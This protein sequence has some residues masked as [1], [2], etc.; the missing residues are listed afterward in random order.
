MPN[1]VRDLTN[2]IFNRLTA[3]E[4]VSHSKPG[5]YWRCLCTCG[6]EVTRRSSQ[7]L[8]NPSQIKS[9]GCVIVE[10]N[11]R[12]GALCYKGNP[13]RV[14]GTIEYFKSNTW[15][16]LQ[17]RTIN[18]TSPHPKNISY[19]RKGV[20]L[21]LTKNEFYTW[22]DSQSATILAMYA[23][24]IKPSINRI[25]PDGHYELSNIEILS[26]F[27]N[28]QQVRYVPKEAYHE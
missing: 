4:R 15:G 27:V 18:G 23:A 22:C 10:H 25:D 5:I 9:C 28:K 8:D 12:R 7:L 16:N 14:R 19:L 13:A 26:D 21:R 24:N 11:K 17:K 20:E 3:L 2:Q 1:I 6:T